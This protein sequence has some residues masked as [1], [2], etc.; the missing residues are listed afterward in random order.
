VLK[1]KVQKKGI[2]QKD[3]GPIAYTKDV[4]KEVC[5]AITMHPVHLTQ[6]PVELMHWTFAKPSKGGMGG[7]THSVRQTE[8]QRQANLRTARLIAFTKDTSAKGTVVRM[9]LQR[10]DKVKIP[11]PHRGLRGVELNTVHERVIITPFTKGQSIPCKTEPKLAC[12]LRRMRPRADSEGNQN[13]TQHVA[14]RSR[15]DQIVFQQR[16]QRKVYPLSR[17]A[18]LGKTGVGV[19][20]QLG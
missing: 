9:V 1:S 2:H 5:N 13:A 16:I 19:K 11:S 17:R 18:E 3:H 4:P 15:L 10:W 8:L 14:V 12:K 7:R 6:K 20:N